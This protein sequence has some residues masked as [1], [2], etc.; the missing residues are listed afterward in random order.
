MKNIFFADE[1]IQTEFASGWMDDVCVI[2]V[3]I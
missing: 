3:K 1:E 2:C